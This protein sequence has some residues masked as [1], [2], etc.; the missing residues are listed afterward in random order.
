MFGRGRAR[1]SAG[2]GLLMLLCCEFVVV[3]CILH[4]I[5]W[6]CFFS[7]FSRVVLLLFFTNLML[8]FS[9][10]FS[11]VVFAV[12]FCYCDGLFATIVL[13]FYCP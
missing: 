12:C 7:V 4:M 8:F 5:S 11:I 6:L 2:Y 9:L 3:L 1:C 13:P 10:N